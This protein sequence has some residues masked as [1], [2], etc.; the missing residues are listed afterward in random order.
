MKVMKSDIQVLFWEEGRGV[1][2]DE[3]GVKKTDRVKSYLVALLKG[4]WNQVEQAV[5]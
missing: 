1:Q 4:Q 3:K 5:L 2:C